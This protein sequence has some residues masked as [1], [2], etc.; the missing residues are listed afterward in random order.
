M[1]SL[2]VVALPFACSCVFACSISSA[3]TIF[4]ADLTGAQEVPAVITN[5]WGT[6][7]L[8][9]SDDQST[10]T[11]VIDTFGLDIGEIKTPEEPGNDISGSHIHIAPAGENGPVVFGIFRPQ[12]DLDRYIT[13]NGPSG[14]IRFQGAWDES[15]VANGAAPLAEQLANLLA[16]KLYINIHTNA[17]PDGEIRGQIVP[18]PSSLALIGL[19]LAT[20]TLGR[21]RRQFAA[22]LKRPV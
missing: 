21:K 22:V 9:L 20:L 19:A 7:T 5:A 6:A 13:I 17:N 16:G 1:S 4:T 15:D 14:L 8:E 11:Y 3:G 18:E 10:L 2:R 12:H